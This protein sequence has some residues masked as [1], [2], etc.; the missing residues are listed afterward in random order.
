MTTATTKGPWFAPSVKK[1]GAG[2]GATTGALPKVALIGCAFLAIA[3]TVLIVELI[4]LLAVFATPAFELTAEMN[5]M[6]RNLNH[7]GALPSAPASSASSAP[8]PAAGAAGAAYDSETGEAFLQWCLGA[9]CLRG[10]NCTDVVLKLGEGV[11]EAT[12]APVIPFPPGFCSTVTM[13]NDQL[14]FCDDEVAAMASPDAPAPAPAFPEEGK[15][16]LDN[17]GFVSMLCPGFGTENVGSK[18]AC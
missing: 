9:P 13:M 15:E 2:A 8:A 10:Q 5:F 11:D 12:G 7:H 3:L 6:M 17:I 18:G 16:L 14:C 1:A 4:T